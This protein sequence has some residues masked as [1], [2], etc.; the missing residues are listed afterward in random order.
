MSTAAEG[1]LKA[2]GEGKNI[3]SGGHIIDQTMYK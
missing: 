1:T 2:T 3:I